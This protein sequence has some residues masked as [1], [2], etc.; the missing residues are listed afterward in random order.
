MGLET[1]QFPKHKTAHGKQ[2]AAKCAARPADPDLER[3][4]RLWPKLGEATRK[5]ILALV[6]VG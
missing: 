5:A 4:V 1:G 2:G 3:V 6:S